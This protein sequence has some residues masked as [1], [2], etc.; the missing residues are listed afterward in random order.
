MRKTFHP[1]IDSRPSARSASPYSLRRDGACW[2]LT[3]AG[4]PAVL[5]HETGLHHIAHLLQHPREP[6]FGLDLAVEA[7]IA[8]GLA[9]DLDRAAV[10]A[11]LSHTSTSPE[12]PVLLLKKQAEL[13]DIL[14][15]DDESEIVKRE[16][17]EELEAITGLQTAHVQDSAGRA[18]R[19][20][21]RAI[22][23]F[24]RRM[25]TALDGR[26]APHPVLRPF[27]GHLHQHLLVPS[28][29]YAASTPC[30]ARKGLFG[31]FI[32]E[33]PPGVRWRCE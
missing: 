19:A 7:R 14:E 32:Y 10:L 16:A 20:V 9:E 26:G 2:T 25:S 17:L 11:Q 5:R 3:F 28:S 27:A 4:R 18:V 13:R 22:H 30:Y 8:S 1:P 24:H 33:P 29:R 31:C 6:F 12:K 23:R 21:R 15:N